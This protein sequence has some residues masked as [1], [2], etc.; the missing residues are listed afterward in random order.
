MTVLPL[1][2]SESTEDKIK[3]ADDRWRSFMFEA[4]DGQDPFVG[5]IGEIVASIRMRS[6]YHKDNLEISLQRRD[7]FRTS[8]DQDISGVDQDIGMSETQ[9]E[10][11]GEE[12]HSLSRLLD[13]FGDALESMIPD[14]SRFLAMR[15]LVQHMNKAKEDEEIDGIM[16]EV[17]GDGEEGGQHAADDEQRPPHSGQA[18]V[19]GF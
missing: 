9:L 6:L 18:G 11:V 2:S 1:S 17:F 8:G 10:E 19:S 3:E 5:Q 7:A 15:D 13:I 12:A 14:K 4:K 16:D